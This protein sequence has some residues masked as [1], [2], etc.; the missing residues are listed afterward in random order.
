MA[1][2]LSA[3]GTRAWALVDPTGGCQALVWLEVAAFR[4]SQ[5]AELF[6]HPELAP[7]AAEPLLTRLLDAMRDDPAGRPLHVMISA[8]APAKSALLQSRGARV[9]RHFFRMVLPLTDATA[10]PVWPPGAEVRAATDT[11]DDLRPIHAT[12]SEAFA[13]HWDHASQDYDGWQQRHRARDDFDPSLWALVRVAGEPA[14]AVICSVNDA[15]GFV[16]AIGVRRPFRGTGLARQLL[17]HSFAE[18]RRRGCAAA[19]LYVDS[20]NPTGAV[21]LYESI[22]MQVAAQWDCHEFAGAGQDGS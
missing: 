13:D 12:I 17:L 2:A 10:P 18:F 16:A 6:I 11:D 20:T 14:A 5:S 3:D 22:G 9:V 19:A 15:G 4:P 21:R 7:P 1:A 8:N